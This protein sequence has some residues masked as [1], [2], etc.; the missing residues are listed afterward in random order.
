M[1]IQSSS[2]D[3]TYLIWNSVNGIEYQYF[4]EIKKSKVQIQTNSFIDAYIYVNS[5]V[6]FIIKEF[7]GSGNSAR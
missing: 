7:K 5:N 1:L 3:Y 6:L 4:V 2:K